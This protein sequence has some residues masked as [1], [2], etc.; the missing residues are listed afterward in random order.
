MCSSDL[1][2]GILIYGPPG[3]GK[4]MIA[5]AV[6]NEAGA[7]FISIKGPEVFSKWVGES[8]KRIR[9][10]FRRARQVA[11]SIIFIDEIDSIAPR[12]GMHSGSH[13][14]EQVVSQML[15]E[16]SGLED[17]TGVVVLA[18]TNRPDMMDPALLRPGR[19]DKMIYVPAP[20][21]K[22]REE[23]LKVHTKDMPTRVDMKKLSEKTDR[24]SGADLE[25]LAREAAMI[26]LR[27]DIE[28]KDVKKE[29]FE[30]ALKKVK[31]SITADIFKKY[32]KLVEEM[33]ETKLEEKARYIG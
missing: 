29:H 11:P 1:A 3:C 31:P 4:T 12:R 5:K 2:R 23:I 22:T 25:A 6:A 10:V 30:N 24:Y 26:A 27:E 33:K 13:V 8:E 17:L 18:A 21:E 19:F 9:E 7:N 28:S 16:M 32:K 15:T 14:T 20:D